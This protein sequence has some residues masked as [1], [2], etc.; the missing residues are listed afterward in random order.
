MEGKKEQK[1]PLRKRQLPLLCVVLCLLAAATA[2]C[3]W[4]NNAGQAAEGSVAIYLKGNTKAVTLVN[5]QYYEISNAGELKE[6]ANP[7]EATLASR[8]N[9]YLY[10]RVVNGEG[11]LEVIQGSNTNNVLELTGANEKPVIEV[12]GQNLTIKNENSGGLKM[13][14]Y[15]EIIKGDNAVSV[16]IES[17]C[18]VTLE[19]R[20]ST[21]EP[22]STEVKLVEAVKD[23]SIVPST[24]GTKPN[25]ILTNEDGEAKK[26]IQVTG[27]LTIDANALKLKTCALGS[28]GTNATISI[29]SQK[30]PEIDT[31]NEDVSDNLGDPLFQAQTVKLSSGA[32][33]KINPDN[34]KKAF[35]R[36]IV[37]CQPTGDNASSTYGTCEIKTENGG[38]DFK[39][40]NDNSGSGA[41]VIKGNVTVVAKTRAQLE[42]E[43]KGTGPVVTGNLNITV[44]EG[45]E[46]GDAVL[47]KALDAPDGCLTTGDLTIKAEKTVNLKANADENAPRTKPAIGGDAKIVAKVIKIEIADSTAIKGAADLQ[48]FSELKVQGGGTAPVIGGASKI[49]SE[50]EMP[51]IERINDTAATQPKDPILGGTL[52]SGNA[53]VKVVE[54]KNKNPT[55]GS[56]LWD[57]KK[58]ERISFTDKNNC[59][60]PVIVNDENV[61][62]T[63][64]AIC[65]AKVSCAEIWTVGGG[66]P[67]KIMEVEISVGKHL[68]TIKKDTLYSRYSNETTLCVKFT[69][70]YYV[71]GDMMDL[72]GVYNIV[73]D[74]NGKELAVGELGNNDKDLKIADSG[75]VEIAGIRPNEAPNNLTIENQTCTIG[76]ITA[77]NNVTL[78][79]GVVCKGD[80]TAGNDVTIS[81]EGAKC[82]GK[83]T[84]TSGNVTI[85]D[86]AKC[87][88]TVKATNG[89]VTIT[90]SECGDI[91]ASGDV[92]ISGGTCGGITAT[93]GNVTVT[94]SECG[95][96]TVK[97]SLEI[98]D[99]TIKGAIENNSEVAW[100]E[101][102]TDSTLLIKNT[103]A[104]LSEL[105][106]KPARVVQ[107]TNSHI[108]IN[109]VCWVEDLTMDKGSV[110]KIGGILT[111]AK[112]ITYGS[113]EAGSTEG[114]QMPKTPFD[115][116]LQYLPSGYSIMQAEKDGS[117]G[118]QHYTVC[119]ENFDMARN[120]ELCDRT[121]APKPAPSGSGTTTN[122]SSGVL[123]T[124]AEIAFA[125]KSFV[126]TGKAQEPKLVVSYGGNILTE[127]KHYRCTYKNNINAGTA[128]VTIEGTGN[129]RGTQTLQFTIQKAERTAPEGL[130][131]KAVSA[132]GK[133][134]GAIGNLTNE[135]EYSK[136]RTNWI[137][138]SAKDKETVKWTGLSTGKYYVRYAENENYLA[139]PAVTLKLT[140]AKKKTQTEQL[141]A[142]AAWKGRKL[143]VKWEK[144]KKA[145]GYEIYVVSYGDKTALKDAAPVKTADAGTLSV[146]LKKLGKKKL[147]RKNN[148]QIVVRAYQLVK[149]KKIYLAES[150]SCI[151][152]GKTNSKYTNPKKIRLAK[153]AYTLTVGDTTKLGAKLVKQNPD[154]KL[155]PGAALRYTTTDSSIAAVT[156]DGT[157]QAKKAGTC[158]I[159][160]TAPNGITATAEV[161]VKP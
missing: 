105:T 19:G 85:T 126:Y 146:K 134:N 121:A 16:K 127:G 155:L 17:S 70:N 32:D 43:G 144:V 6:I 79:G 107:V 86:N 125:E 84:A 26:T 61:S 101:T 76:A 142:M 96:I 14:G 93:S 10:Y 111:N 18:P 57:V 8:L 150:E 112:K 77:E 21:S 104:T 91:T 133:K 36:T 71:P 103:R 92:K 87:T 153:K 159:V 156:A 5:E 90:S 27:N 53:Y 15:G 4:G 33:I 139:S 29:S 132:A 131:V 106:W 114:T 9:P 75:S 129:F 124:A 48:A 113:G 60:H 89:A 55:T 66:N 83:I 110:I 78:A 28:S 67:K 46:T 149:G 38:V 148:Y 39:V 81:G 44:T 82:D 158:L 35:P 119:N 160:L 99:G 97:K 54:M 3:L 62:R 120:F 34:T 95:G 80:I 122:T 98:T 37:H 20:K 52:E 49:T 141:P 115:G 74:P 63:K 22:A 152:A 154:K 145:D 1:Q 11:I 140:V 108:E 128:S 116:I 12:K 45:E 51:V 40:T 151:L 56:Y 59:K 68:W 23:F 100:D 24:N 138:V 2:F 109:G 123:I 72:E 50:N 130:T 64:C 47:V 73:L 25:V 88:G 147:S 135:M 7:V 42:T 31:T 157:L 137:R 117:M 58:S 41:G 69:K 161:I 136:N 118:A 65:G 102:A 13:V 94:K 30:T 143:F